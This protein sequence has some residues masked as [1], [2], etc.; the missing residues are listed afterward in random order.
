MDNTARFSNRVANYVLYRPH[1]S[2]AIIPFLKTEIGFTT[3]WIIADIGSGTGLSSEHFINNG[4][5][6]FALEDIEAMR[7]EAESIN[8]KIPNYVS[9]NG[10]A[11]NT[12]LSDAS[13]DLIIAGQAFH[14]FD[15]AKAKTEFKRIGK[16]NCYTI[17]M[18][19]ER[20]TDD[21]LAKEYDER[22][23][24]FAPDYSGANH[25]NIDRAIIRDFFAPA[26]YQI[27]VFPNFQELDWEGLKGRVLSSSYAPLP[28]DL[29]YE[30]M[31]QG[32]EEIFKKYAVNG[33]VKLEYDC[34]IYYGELEA[35]TKILEPR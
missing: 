1:Y 13:V 15:R 8:R 26:E 31:M 19:N 33:L 21:A 16:R 3:D 18:W 9:I 23:R 32:L 34:K 6:V 2:A 30:P 10:T 29:N 14:W 20:K 24:R 27:K 7:L 17:L 25:R 11:E 35:R 22:L 4:N 28:G 5:M 12:G